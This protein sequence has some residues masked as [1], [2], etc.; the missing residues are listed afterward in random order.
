[1]AYI[2]HCR[3]FIMYTPQYAPIA[4]L[5]TALDQC[6]LSHSPLLVRFWRTF[7]GPLARNKDE[8]VGLKLI[9]VQ[10]P[11]VQSRYAAKQKTCSADDPGGLAARFCFRF[12]LRATLQQNRALPS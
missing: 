7:A 4:K 8:F 3:T 11:V 6:D 10:C 2:D 5:V 9:A 12:A 1:M